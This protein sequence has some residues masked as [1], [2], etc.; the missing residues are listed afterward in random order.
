[1]R[2]TNES[3]TIFSWLLF[4]IDSYFVLHLVSPAE[5]AVLQRRALS[6]W[7]FRKVTFVPG[8]STR[9]RSISAG[10]AAVAADADVIVV[11]DAVRP[12]V[13]KNHSLLNCSYPSYDREAFHNIGS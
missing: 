8:G 2:W 13:S 4:I 10:V 6:E 7:K 1:M 9:H 12:F 5:V 3:C 11:H